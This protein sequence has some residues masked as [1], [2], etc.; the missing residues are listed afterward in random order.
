MITMMRVTILPY[1]PN[2]VV[3]PFHW[4]TG[5]WFVGDGY[6]SIFRTS[7]YSRNCWIFPGGGGVA[8]AVVLCRCSCLLCDGWTHQYIFTNMLGRNYWWTWT[9]SPVRPCPTRVLYQYGREG[10]N[11]LVVGLCC[12]Y[13][14]YPG[15]PVMEGL[16]NA[17]VKVVVILFINRSCVVATI[18][19]TIVP[20]RVF[21]GTEWVLLLLLL[22]MILLP[23]LQPILPLLVF[24]LLYWFWRTIMLHWN[25][26]SAGV[27]TIMC[28]ACTYP[29]CWCCCIWW[30]SCFDH[31]TALDHS[32]IR[33][34]L[35]LFLLLWFSLHLFLLH[36]LFVICRC[37]SHFN[38]LRSYWWWWCCCNSYCYFFSNVQCAMYLLVH[39][40]LLLLFLLLL[41]IICCRFFFHS[42]ILCSAASD[43]ISIDSTVSVSVTATATAAFVFL[44]LLLLAVSRYID[45]RYYYYYYYFVWVLLFAF[46][47]NILIFPLMITCQWRCHIMSLSYLLWYCQRRCHSMDLWYIF[48]G[49]VGGSEAI[50][51]NNFHPIFSPYSR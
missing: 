35:R 5:R 6:V 43:S 37:I 23:V 17:F 11:N 34:V 10:H 38:I 48:F 50:Q 16:P 13:S 33:G 51:S 26:R 18:V 28:C 40:L 21:S 1:N 44:F 19:P 30:I 27:V 8:V 22:L 45:F 15:F 47:F 25:I 3:V 7:V 36:L 2:T 31:W 12:L 14:F 39:L 32:V 9:H 29:L 41:F 46:I 42:I 4:W 20:T 24:L 49:D